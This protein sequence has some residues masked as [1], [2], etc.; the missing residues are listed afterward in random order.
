MEFSMQILKHKNE[1]K[2][3]GKIM[4]LGFYKEDVRRKGNGQE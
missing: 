1:R 4:I 2:N 3:N